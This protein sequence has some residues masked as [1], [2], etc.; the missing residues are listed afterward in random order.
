MFDALPDRFAIFQWPAET[1][2]APPAARHLATS[3]RAARQCDR[4]GRAGYGMQ[5][6]FEA[7]RAMMQDR[8]DTFADLIRGIDPGWHAA[9]PDRLATIG[10]RSDVHGLTI[11]GNRVA[12][13]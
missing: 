5:F 2:T 6:H 10:R 9:L 11:A 12:L 3:L 4:F 8:S 1:F 7:N 13:I